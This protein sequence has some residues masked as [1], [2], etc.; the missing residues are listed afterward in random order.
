MS[1]A[2][3][4]KAARHKDI[5]LA[6][7]TLADGVVLHSPLTDRIT[8]DGKEDVRSLFEAAYETFEGLEY[9]TV[10][11]GRVLVGTAT[12][13]GQPFEETLVMHVDEDG[14]FDEITLFIRPLPGLTAV[15]AALGPSLA[16]RNGRRTGGLLRF[17]TAPL[18]AA[19][20]AGDR[21]GIGLALPRR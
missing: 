18:L 20:R 14:R 10:I 1:I 19:T 12:V 13:N 4:Q 15:L 11:G 17:L 5:D 7:S 2:D 6:M 9:H 21:F 8:F 16:R 3:F